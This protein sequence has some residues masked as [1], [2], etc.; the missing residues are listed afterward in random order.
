VKT[1]EKATLIIQAGI[2]GMLARRSIQGELPEE[3][4]LQDAA[5]AAADDDGGGDG[6]G[7]DAGGDHADAD[8]NV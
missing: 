2:R 8:D 4:E 6:D 3:Q 7:D 5:A 1:K